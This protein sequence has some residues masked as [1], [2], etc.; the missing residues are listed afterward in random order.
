MC[1]GDDCVELS[2]LTGI[3]LYW[4]DCLIIMMYISLWFVLESAPCGLRSIVEY[5]HLVSWPSIVKGG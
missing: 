2:L 5:A 4:Y 3:V 1:P